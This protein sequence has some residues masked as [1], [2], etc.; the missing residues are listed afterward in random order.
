MD[1]QIRLDD[2]SV[3]T[4]G[5]RASPD[6]P[7]VMIAIGGTSAGKVILSSVLL[8]KEEAQVVVKTLTEHI[9]LC[10]DKNDL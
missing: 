1:S 2:Q 10:E 9:A 8:T 5:L 6:G 4:V 7:T 3:V